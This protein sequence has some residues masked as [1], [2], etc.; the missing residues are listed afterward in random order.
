MKVLPFL[1]ADLK[2]VSHNPRITKRIVLTKGECGSISQLS[3]AV[4]P[5]GETAHAHSHED[6][7]EIFIV[8]S[9]RGILRID[10]TRHELKPDVCAVVEPLETHE[11]SNNGASDLVIIVIG[12]D[13]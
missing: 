8:Q 12:I 11:I 5:P 2:A 6:M 13:V 3:Q 10:K 4:F 9:G 7:T 1:E